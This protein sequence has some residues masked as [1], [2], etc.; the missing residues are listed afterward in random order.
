[1][2]PDWLQLRYSEGGADGPVEQKGQIVEKT[3]TESVSVSQVARRY[4]VEANQAF[5]R[6]RQ[7]R[8]GEVRPE[9]HCSAALLAVTMPG[10]REDAGAQ[11]Q[12]AHSGGGAIR[13]RHGRS[14]ML[15]EHHLNLRAQTVKF[16][17]RSMLTNARPGNSK[18]RPRLLEMY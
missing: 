4:G 5:Q 12:A 18:R 1:M 8:A 6:R 3:Q 16:P 7:Y 10:T 13:Q 15:F 2:K 9:T 11:A 14:R 17:P